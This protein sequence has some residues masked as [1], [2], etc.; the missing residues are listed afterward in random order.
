MTRTHGTSVNRDRVEVKAKGYK[1]TLV[2]GLGS[3][4][5]V[6]VTAENEK[7]L[8][9]F[10]VY[11]LIDRDSINNYDCVV[12]IN[13]K[14]INRDLVIEAMEDLKEYK[15]YT[16]SEMKFIALGIFAMVL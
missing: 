14:E 7:S 15:G 9:Q 6:S 2:N 5:N 10:L 13:D 11:D 3:K 1:V 16:H 12:A 4:Y 8:L